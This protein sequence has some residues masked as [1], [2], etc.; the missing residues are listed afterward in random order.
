VL[1][2][3]NAPNLALYNTCGVG[4]KGDNPFLKFLFFIY[5]IQKY[6][7]YFYYFTCIFFNIFLFEGKENLLLLLF[8]IN[9]YKSLFIYMPSEATITSHQFARPIPWIVP[10]ATNMSNFRHW[11][12]Q[13]V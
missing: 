5:F 9:M 4:D 6:R 13:I 7:K 8:A 10:R 2:R 3:I 1:L 11:A 12:I